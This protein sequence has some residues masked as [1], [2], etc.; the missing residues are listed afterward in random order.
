MMS[1]WVIELR[2][3]HWSRSLRSAR[4]FQSPEAALVYAES[5]VADPE[6]WNEGEGWALCKLLEAS[7]PEHIEVRIKLVS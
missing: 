7:D 4:A 6:I 3:P 1:D 2:D 5:L